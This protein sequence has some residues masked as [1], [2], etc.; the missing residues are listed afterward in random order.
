MLFFFNGCCRFGVFAAKSKKK[1]SD[2]KIILIALCLAAAVWAEGDKSL[3][4]IVQQAEEYHAEFLAQQTEL[5][6]FEENANIERAALLPQISLQGSDS[7]IGTSNSSSNANWRLGLKLSQPIVNFSA[8]IKWRAAIDETALAAINVAAARN[9]LRRAVVNAW[10]DMQ[11]LSDELELVELR[12]KTLREQ[13]KRARLLADAGRGTRTDVTSA[14]AGLALARAQREQAKHDLSVA[15]DAL[16]HLSGESVPIKQLS[17]SPAK[18]PALA[19]LAKWQQRVATNSL[20]LAAKRQEIV[21]L[22]QLLSATRMALIPKLSLEGSLE[23]V[24]D[25][26]E[27][28]DSVNIVLSQQLFA[29]GNLMARNR[30]AKASLA[31]ARLRLEDIARRQTQEV[32]RLH[33][34]LMT[35]RVRMAALAAAVDASEAVLRDVVAGY[36]AGVRIAQEVVSAEEDVFDSRLQLRRAI[37]DYLKN[38]STLSELATDND[39]SFVAQIGQFFADAKY[40]R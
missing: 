11:L 15:H 9:A 18:L 30:Q 3:L 7:I 14:E 29:G 17:V 19:P 1:S 35:N 12:V 26:D 13:A 23:A 27:I 38:L 36:N 16:L 22:K 28:N 37:Y 33:S 6:V 31:V 4:K 2:I 5:T 24:D 8:L 32:A 39:D 34:Q 10:L 21:Y 25:F 40:A 20:A